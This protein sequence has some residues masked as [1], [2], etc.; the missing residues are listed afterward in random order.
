V[1][2]R[3]FVM[4]DLHLQMWTGLPRWRQPH[5]LASGSFGS[6]DVAGSTFF[7]RFAKTI[8]IPRLHSPCMCR[9]SRHPLPAQLQPSHYQ[10][11]AQRDERGVYRFL[12]R[13]RATL[14][15]ADVGTSTRSPSRPVI[16]IL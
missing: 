3:V 1:D 16:S 9:Q 14:T 5:L 11:P 13:R 7:L 12:Q 2:E 15:N 6:I 8:E 10:P 4:D